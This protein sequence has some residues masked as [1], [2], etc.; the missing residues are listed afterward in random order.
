MTLVSSSSLA[1]GP[2]NTSCLRVRCHHG[3]DSTASAVRVD[4][5]GSRNHD[6]IKPIA[7]RG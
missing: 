5:L 7:S 6:N 3:W 4:V 2:E 1:E